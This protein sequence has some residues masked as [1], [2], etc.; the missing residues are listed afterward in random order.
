MKN[1]FSKKLLAI[2]TI[3][4]ISSCGVYTFNGSTL[5]SHLKTVS[6]PLFINRSTQPDVAD[7]LTDKLN[8]RLLSAN[9]LRVVQN[10]GDA[11][12][13]GTV[14]SYSNAPYTYGA[15]GTR[16]VDVSEYAVKITVDVQFKDQKKDADLYKGVVT[17]TGVYAY[18]TETEA[19]GNQKAMD[20]IIDQILQNS[21]QSW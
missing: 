8:K 16:Q 6:V 18:G 1:L 11:I 10:N 20:N 2:L 5:P 19:I 14:L 9:L 17:G 4:I 12:I 21:V 7:Q 3:A 13:N 15:A